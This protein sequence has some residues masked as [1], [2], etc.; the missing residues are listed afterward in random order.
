MERTVTLPLITPSKKRPGPKESMIS[1]AGAAIPGPRLWPVTRPEAREHKRMI[2]T[3]RHAHTTELPRQ[4]YGNPMKPHLILL[5]VLV[6]C[7]GVFAGETKFYY[8]IDPVDA[9]TLYVACKQGRPS[10]NMRIDDVL[11]VRCPTPQTK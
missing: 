2:G 1:A 5:V 9:N 7:A 4:L 3:D 10:T 8:R 6:F 11:I